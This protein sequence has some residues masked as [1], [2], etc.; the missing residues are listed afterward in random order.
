[1]NCPETNEKSVDPPHSGGGSQG[2]W[3]GG[4]NISK[5]REISW[6]AE[7]IDTLLITP[8]LPNWWGGG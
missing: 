5:V 2:N 6:T 3:G 4:V 7:K 8:P 1:M